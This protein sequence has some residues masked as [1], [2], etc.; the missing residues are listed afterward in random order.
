MML[1]KVL[2]GL[3]GVLTLAVV[4]IVVVLATLDFNQY[5]GVIAEQAKAATGRDLR[6]DGD[7]EVG[8]SFVPSLMV[9]G[10]SLSNADWGSRPQMLTLERVEAKV[11]LIPLLFGTVDVRRFIL[12]GVDL[13]LETD[14]DGR[15]NWTMAPSGTA[16]EAAPAPADGEGGMGALPVIREVVLKDVKLTYVDGVAGETQTIAIERLMAGADSADSPLSFELAVA[17]NGAPIEVGGTVGALAAAMAGDVP[18]PVEIEASA[19]DATATVNGSIARLHEAKGID[20]TL[21]ARVADLAET[22]AAAQAALPQLKGAAPPPS[23]SIDLS[24]RVRDTAGGYAVEDLM[25]KA[26]SSDLA[27]SISAALDGPRPAVVARL[28]STLID[29]NDFVGAGGGGD[30][31]TPSDDGAEGKKTKLFSSDPLPLDGLRAVDADLTYQGRKVV[32]G[33]L[34]VENVDLAVL[35]RNGRLSVTPKNADL[36]QGKVS[37]AVILDA[38]A[39]DAV[40]L[41][42]DLKVAKLLAGTLAE[43]LTGKPVLEGGMTDVD[44]TLKGRGGSVAALMGGLNGNLLVNVGKGTIDNAY[45]DLAGG[46][47]LSNLVPTLTGEKKTSELSC[48]VLNVNITD[49]LARIDKGL[50]VETSEQL[51]Q[52]DGEINLKTEDLTLRVHPRMTDSVGASAGGIA[53]LVK[54]SGTLAEPSIGLDEL[55][56]AKTALSAVG[57]V[58]TGGLS[59]VAESALDSALDDDYP[60]LT[61]LGKEPPADAASGASSG[62]DSTDGGSSASGAAKDLGGKIKGLFGN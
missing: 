19:F 8:I 45:V 59:L 33:N 32:A 39:G 20:L 41:D 46:N 25:F 34:V 47:L 13:L 15:A 36:A 43:D 12:E 55:G 3:A 30:A 17:Y 53:K 48:A 4:A 10:V 24:A 28:A 58:A 14:A 40:A 54:V 11:G 38:S 37:G 22:F 52:G 29:T 35:L 21:G 5:K 16:A 26:G 51:A 7:I 2:I 6:I 50:A 57:A 18:F 1:K 49:G 42:V 23:T 56:I 61:A 44:V 60:C 31:A 9:D 62:S 27:G